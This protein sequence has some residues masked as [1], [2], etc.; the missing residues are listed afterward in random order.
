[1]NN[2]QVL[3]DRVSENDVANLNSFPFFAPPHQ[4]FLPGTID[5]GTRH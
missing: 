2:R 5:D 4:P 1:V 3:G